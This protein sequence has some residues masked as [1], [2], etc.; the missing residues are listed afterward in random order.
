MLVALVIDKKVGDHPRHNID[1]LKFNRYVA[2]KLYIRLHRFYSISSVIVDRP[3]IV[4]ISKIVNNLSPNFTI[5]LSYNHYDGMLHGLQVEYYSNS[6]LSN[7]LGN[8]MKNAILDVY[9]H[10]SLPNIVHSGGS[11]KASM[12]GNM[13]APTAIINPFFIDNADDVGRFAKKSEYIHSLSE[14]INTFINQNKEI[15]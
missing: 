2:R 7:V 1:A 8:T 6:I 11:L 5:F 3:S 12:L 4:D 14:G 10:E 15:L 9:K 13:E